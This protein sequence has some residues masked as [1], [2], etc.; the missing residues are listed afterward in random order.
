MVLDRYGLTEAYRVPFD[1]NA[2]LESVALD[3]DFDS[4]RHIYA[5]V[6][7]AHNDGRL[8]SVVRFREVAGTIGEPHHVPDIPIPSMARR[9]QWGP[10][11]IGTWRCL[12]CPTPLQRRDGAVLRFD[13][14]GAAKGLASVASPLITKS[15]P[16]PTKL[17]WNNDRFGW[18]VSSGHSITRTDEYTP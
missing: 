11:V 5:A 12:A 16:R 7:S 3:V 15:N 2:T 17:S 13:L 1:S 18:L 9:C 10:I 14:T 4:I 6:A 8:L